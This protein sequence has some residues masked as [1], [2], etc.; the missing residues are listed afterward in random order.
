MAW[1]L[2]E[3]FQ[4]QT[5]FTL[6]VTNLYFSTVLHICYTRV[7]TTHPFMYDTPFWYR[8]LVVNFY[9]FQQQRFPRRKSWFWSRRKVWCAVDHFYH[10][11]ALSVCLSGRC[12]YLSR[13]TTEENRECLTLAFCLTL[14]SS[15]V[16]CWHSQGFFLVVFAELLTPWLFFFD[17][18][19]FGQTSV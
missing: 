2:R 10:I 12:H 14:A 6:S 11:L 16:C 7:S 1:K 15:Q 9:K 17:T 8:Q 18:R 13:S 4:D 5:C 3:I 19:Q